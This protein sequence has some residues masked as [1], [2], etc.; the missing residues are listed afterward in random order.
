MSLF[1]SIAKVFGYEK[2]NP[3]TTKKDFK[4]WE[5]IPEDT[6]FNPLLNEAPPDWKAED[7]L[8]NVKGWVYACVAAIAD[9][10]AGIELHLYRQTGDKIEEVST[11]SLLDLLYRVN[12]F[13]TK[14]DHWWLTQNYLELTGE[15]PWLLDRGGG[16]EP[17]GIYLL[18]PDKLTIKFSPDKVVEGYVYE[19]SP[20]EKTEFAAEDVIFLKYPNPMKPFRGRGTL[21]AAIQTVDLDF[22]SEK[23]NLNFMYNQARPDAVLTTEQKLSEEQIIRMNKQWDK[24]F[25]GIDKIARLAILE[26][27]VKYQ[28][29]QLSQKDMDFLEQQKFSRDKI[30]SIFRVPK[31]IIAISDDVNRANAETG[32]YAFARWTIKAKMKRIVEQLNEF[33]VPL[34]GDDLF[35]DFEDPV[36]ENR[37]LELLAYEKAL[38]MNGWMTINEVRELEGLKPVEGGDVVFRPIASVPINMDLGQS[39]PP[40]AGAAGIDKYRAKII[41]LHAK[42]NLDESINIKDEIKRVIKFHLKNKDNE[43]KDKKLLGIKNPELFWKKQITIGAKY[44]RIFMVR[45]RKLFRSQAEM[46]LRNLRQSNKEILARLR[47]ISDLTN[48][49]GQRIKYWSEMKL[50]VDKLMLDV[51]KEAKKF[52]AIL[53]PVIS[54]AIAD[55]GQYTLDSMGVDMEFDFNN[56]VKIYLAKH[57]MKFS[58][59]VNKTT[60]KKLSATLNEGV[61]NG[62]SIDDLASRVEDV[63]NMTDRSRSVLI[64]RTETSRAVNFATGEAYRQSKVVEGKQWLTAMDERT[65]DECESMDGKIVDVDDNFFDQGDEYRGLVFDY[66]DVGE[67][68]LHDMCRCTIIPVILND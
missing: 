6:S 11:H 26:G 17:I 16:T 40:T 51:K 35:L 9:E 30:F 61:A 67:P 36:P 28:Q 47:Q 68:P 23:Y 19:T 8:K 29:L 54:G 49:A 25:K 1:D 20:T 18:R 48:P 64:A 24:K 63:F 37:E 59:S 3:K 15:A 14:F 56:N 34:Y 32:A 27:G 58:T 66:D 60:N 45:V 38:S 39:V 50:N 62:E 4:P 22:Y 2:P 41:S 33:L 55:E 42:K 43:K 12:D 7:Y 21:E 31:S 65:C 57:P 46:V 10:V 13:T 5:S 44:E 52:A 53:T